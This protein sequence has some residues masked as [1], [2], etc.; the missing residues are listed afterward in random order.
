MDQN[1]KTELEIKEKN[2]ALTPLDKKEL[3]LLRDLEKVIADQNS[4]AAKRAGGAV[5]GAEEEKAE[6]VVIEEPE[7][8]IEEEKVDE[9][10]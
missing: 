8:E 3:K 9:G 5:E 1:R 2:N 4:E 10:K 7:E 6:E